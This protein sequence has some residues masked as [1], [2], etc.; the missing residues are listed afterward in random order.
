M[1]KK[2]MK[3]RERLMYF[4]KNKTNNQCA[5]NIFN[6]LTAQ[7]TSGEMKAIRKRIEKNSSKVIDGIEFLKTKVLED[8]EFSA[9]IVPTI[10]SSGSARNF[11]FSNEKEPTEDEVYEWLYLTLT[12]LYSRTYLVNLI[13]VNEETKKC[14]REELL[15]TRVMLPDRRGIDAKQL[16]KVCPVPLCSGEHVLAFSILNYFV[17]WCK[18]QL[19]QGKEVKNL[20][21]IIRD[22][23]P[24][25]ELQWGITDET[26]LIIFDV[27]RQ[28][29]KMYYIPKVNGFIQR[30]YAEYFIDPK[31]ISPP[32]GQFMASLYVMNPR[33][34]KVSE[35]LLNK[36]TYYLLRN[37]PHGEIL[38]KCVLLKTE[39]ILADKQQKRKMG[40]RCADMF[41][42]K[43]GA[44]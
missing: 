28:K 40:I 5:K 39:S 21:K 7:Y 16:N 23:L 9:S 38:E 25:L 27:P 33:Y 14:F 24:N 42:S 37:E 12:S 11:L 44:T 34:R 43:I 3:I 17:Y 41:Y 30:W 18:Q 15:S 4:L 26:A 13:N 31:Q 8:K 2:N 6:M 10:I 29:K 1:K 32:L 20:E 22:L 36:L 19:L 35:D